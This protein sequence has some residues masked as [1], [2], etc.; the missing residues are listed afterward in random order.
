MVTVKIKW[1]NARSI[2]IVCQYLV[3]L[4]SHGFLIFYIYFKALL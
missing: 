2:S 4:S 3:N 1:D